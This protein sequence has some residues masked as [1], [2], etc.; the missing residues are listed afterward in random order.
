VT[1]NTEKRSA[2]IP[3][4]QS[5]RQTCEHANTVTVPETG[6]SF[7]QTCGLLIPDRPIEIGSRL[8]PPSEFLQRAAAKY[9]ELRLEELRIQT[10]KNTILVSIAKVQDRKCVWPGCDAAAMPRGKWCPIHKHEHEREG[11]RERQRCRR[12]SLEAI[13]RSGSSP[14]GTQQVIG[15]I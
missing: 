13:P 5:F 3:I 9:Q 4:S 7:C 1:E 15:T 8:I 10:Q 2:E 6:Q 14:P 12:R 11:A